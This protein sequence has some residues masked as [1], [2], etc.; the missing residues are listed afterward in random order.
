MNDTHVSSV[1]QRTA[2]SAQ[3]YV[4]FYVRADTPEAAPKPA[5]LSTPGGSPVVDLLKLKSEKLKE[6]WSKKTEN[7]GT[8]R[9]FLS[10]CLL[11]VGH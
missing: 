11:L 9:F 2:L 4:L 1:S 5:V 10:S 7:T 8:P 3:A 6:T